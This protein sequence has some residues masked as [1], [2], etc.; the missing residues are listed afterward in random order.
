MKLSTN[1]EYIRWENI[2]TEQ[3]LIQQLIFQ[4][5]RA[6]RRQSLSE[7]GF[8]RLDTYTKL[9]KLGEVRHSHLL[10]K[11]DHDYYYIT[12]PPSQHLLPLVVGLRCLM[13]YYTLR[14]K[15]SWSQYFSFIVLITSLFTLLITTH[16]TGTQEILIFSPPAAR[17]QIFL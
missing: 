8:G 16:N 2:T 12:L 15:W 9:D 13:N 7:I 17:T 3:L 6:I 11:A 4:F 5:S 10:Y 1:D 14:I